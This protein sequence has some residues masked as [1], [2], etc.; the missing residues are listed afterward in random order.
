MV[1]S[2]IV[3]ME[4]LL[5]QGSTIK[6]RESSM[7]YPYS[8][9][10]DQ[11]ELVAYSPTKLSLCLVFFPKNMGFFFN[12]QQLCIISINS[13]NFSFC[14]PNDS[15]VFFSMK[16]PWPNHQKEWKVK[17]DELMDQ[18]MPPLVLSWLMGTRGEIVEN[19]KGIWRN[20]ETSTCHGQTIKRMKSKGGWMDHIMTP[21][22]LSWL[23]GTTWRNSEN[24]R[25]TGEIK[26]TLEQYF[27]VARSCCFS[28]IH[29]EGCKKY[30]IW[31]VLLTL[32]NHVG[33]L[34]V[35]GRTTLK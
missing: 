9:M 13:P 15:K 5:R 18:I 6:R 3:K 32:S 19:L 11:F 25:G 20:K 27:I 23:S 29:V 26:K 35:A 33:V 22:A 34:I 1:R 7:L 14:L 12:K 30:H 21:S 16:H 10:L 2:S 28:Y 17:G 8:M 24:I 31:F 4:S